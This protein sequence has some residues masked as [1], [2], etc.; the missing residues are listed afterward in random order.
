ML[1]ALYNL[2]SICQYHL[3]RL[4]FFKLGIDQNCH[5]YS[6]KI[7]RAMLRA[8]FLLITVVFVGIGNFE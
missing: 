3:S 2:Q 4:Y 5:R 6:Y 7:L 8:P 1:C